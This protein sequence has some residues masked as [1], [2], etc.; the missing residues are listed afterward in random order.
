MKTIAL[1]NGRTIRGI[2][3]R[4]ISDA[5]VQQWSFLEL[6]ARDPVSELRR[7][8]SNL[9]GDP[10]RRDLRAARSDRKP[11]FDV[12]RSAAFERDAG[13]LRRGES[14]FS[15]RERVNGIDGETGDTEVTLRAGFD[16]ALQAVRRAAESN[17]DSC[18]GR[19][20][21][22]ENVAAEGSGVRRLGEQNSE[23]RP[24]L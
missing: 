23:Q 19:V 8:G 18:H 5:A 3:Q 1:V 11:K 12:R 9:A 10:R 20:A 17:R 14:F 22:V 16:R 4:K 2:E 21:L 15:R 6:P 13:E 7:I 24:H